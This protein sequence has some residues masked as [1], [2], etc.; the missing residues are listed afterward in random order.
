MNKLVNIFAGKEELIYFLCHLGVIYFIFP[1]KT[2]SLSRTD[3]E[4]YKMF[5]D[6]GIATVDTCICCE[7]TPALSSI[8]SVWISGFPLCTHICS[9]LR[10][11]PCFSIGSFSCAFRLRMLLGHMACTLFCCWQF[12]YI[13]EFEEEHMFE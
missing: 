3:Y 10:F 4:I 11:P 6:T 13:G 2:L 9:F 12:F 7:R 1:S 5:W 8:L